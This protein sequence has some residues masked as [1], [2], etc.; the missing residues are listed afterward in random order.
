MA[1]TPKIGNLSDITSCGTRVHGRPMKRGGGLW[2]DWEEESLWKVQESPW[3]VPEEGPCGW[4][5]CVGE[6]PGPGHSRSHGCVENVCIC[7]NRE[8]MHEVWSRELSHGRRCPGVPV[9]SCWGPEGGPGLWGL[10]T[11][12]M[13]E[14]AEHLLKRSPRCAGT[15]RDRKLWAARPQRRDQTVLGLSVHEF[16]FSSNLKI[17]SHQKSR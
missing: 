11:R 8:K 15:G 5:R 13:Q 14:R 12:S 16:E 2:R 1:N 4:S 3:K 17:M 9:G 10:L 6:G 7:Q